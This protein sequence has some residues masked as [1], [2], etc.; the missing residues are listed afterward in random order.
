MLLIPFDPSNVLLKEPPHRQ[1]PGSGQLDQLSV[2]FE[3]E[4]AALRAQLLAEQQ[5]LNSESLPGVANCLADVLERNTM[6][7]PEGPQHV[8]LDQIREGEKRW[9]TRR[10]MNQRTKVPDAIRL[11]KRTANNPRTQR[12]VRH[13]QVTCCFSDRISRFASQIV[14]GVAP[15]ADRCI[16]QWLC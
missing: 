7:G 13:P 8:R 6:L 11:G 2:A 3:Q 4:V 14:E 10:R 5:A 12:G 15:R 9:I 1:L 16:V